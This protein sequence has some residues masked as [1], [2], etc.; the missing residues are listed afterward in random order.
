MDKSHSVRLLGLGFLATSVQ[1]KE[2]T[3]F[4]SCWVWGFFWSRGGGPC[5]LVFIFG[6][7]GINKEMLCF[8]QLFAYFHMYFKALLFT[9]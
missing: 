5:V 4:K 1:Q 3:R 2:N 8:N 9:D 6:V 7:A